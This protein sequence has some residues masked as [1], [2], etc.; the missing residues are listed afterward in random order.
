MSVSLA[1]N[2]AQR[3][4]QVESEA[5]EKQ[6]EQATKR[7][8]MAALA[9]NVQDSQT[10]LEDRLNNLR[11][12]ADQM[13]LAAAEARKKMLSRKLT[14]QHLRADLSKVKAERWRKRCAAGVEELI[15]RQ[16]VLVDEGVEAALNEPAVVP[17]V[18]GQG[19]L[20]STHAVEEEM[21]AVGM[22]GLGEFQECTRLEGKDR[23]EEEEA[24]CALK[25]QATLFAGDGEVA[26]AH[27]SPAKTATSPANDAA[28]SPANRA[29]APSR[30]DLATLQA[31]MAIPPPARHQLPR[32]PP[33]QA[34][35]RGGDAADPC[36]PLAVGKDVEGDT[37][38]RLDL[39]TP[40]SLT[41]PRGVSVEANNSVG[42]QMEEVD[43]PRVSL[44]GGAQQ[45]A[46]ESGRDG[47]ARGEE[48]WRR[49]AREAAGQQRRAEEEK[50]RAEEEQRRAEAVAEDVRKEN[51]KLRTML[52]CFERPEVDEAGRE[53]LRQILASL[54]YHDNASSPPATSAALP[55]A[56]STC[57]RAEAAPP[58][59]VP[60]VAAETAAA[61]AAATVAAAA[62]CPTSHPAS[63][64]EAEEE[65]GTA[66]L[67]GGPQ[68]TDHGGASRSARSASPSPAARFH[69]AHGP[70]DTA[71]EEDA[72]AVAPVAEA[73]TPAAPSAAVVAAG[74]DS[75]AEAA[76]AAATSPPPAAAA[77][78]AAAAVAI[79]SQ[80][81][82]HTCA[83]AQFAT[84]EC[85]QDSDNNSQSLAP[86]GVI[87]LSDDTVADESP[88]ES[89][90]AAAASG[91]IGDGERGGG[92]NS[93]EKSG[94]SFAGK[95]VTGSGDEREAEEMGAGGER[96]SEERSAEGKDRAES[97]PEG[98]SSVDLT[99][100]IQRLRARSLR[101]LTEAEAKRRAEEEGAAASA[102][103]GEGEREGRGD[104]GD[105]E[106]GAAAR[107]SQG[108]CEAAEGKGLQEIAGAAACGGGDDAAHAGSDATG[109]AAGDIAQ[110][111]GNGRRRGRSKA[112]SGVS[113][114]E[115]LVE[116]GGVGAVRKGRKRAAE[117]QETS[118]GS[119][120]VTRSQVRKSAG[121]G[122]EEGS[123]S[124][125]TRAESMHEV[126]MTDVSVADQ[127]F[128]AAAAADDDDDVAPASAPAAAVTTAAATA[129]DSGG[130][131][132]KRS[133]GKA[134]STSAA[135]FLQGRSRSVSS[136]RGKRGCSSNASGSSR[137]GNTGSSKRQSRKLSAANCNSDA[138]AGG[139]AESDA[140]AAHGEKIFLTPPLV[141]TKAGNEKQDS[142]GEGSGKAA[143]TGT[144]GRGLAPGA[145]ELCSGR[146]GV[147]E[148]PM[149]GEPPH[150][151]GEIAESTAGSQP[152]RS[153]SLSAARCLAA[154]GTHSPVLT[155][156]FQRAFPVPKL[157]GSGSA[158]SCS[159]ASSSRSSRSIRRG[160]SSRSSM[161]GGSGGSKKGGAKGGAGGAGSRSA[162]EGG[163][164]GGG[165]AGVGGVSSQ[166]S[167]V[168]QALAFH[169]SEGT[170]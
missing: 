154:L 55:P 111:T 123:K 73:P 43:Q 21:E 29:T 33:P 157:K 68:G 53:I 164:R 169:E 146:L 76:P 90:T 25:E 145:S 100:M 18:G 16:A 131:S 103:E 110:D 112:D 52:R 6:W 134:S 15:K 116:E 149:V 162:G 23:G 82:S 119:G 109:A 14:I 121:K 38:A 97:C 79:P 158:S 114:R 40:E 44:L 152:I 46:E 49:V 156:F 122:E 106:D 42:I 67:S 130:E 167:L 66:A 132:C 12:L 150:T 165:G 70:P 143:G 30:D 1:G 99:D 32:T 36:P 137:S 166:L 64:A 126:D 86:P 31:A 37:A 87:S 161:G 88:R 138:A 65:R 95:G 71:A 147:S 34:A 113:G 51:E 118:Y 124:Q 135:A 9:R 54:P 10:A 94:G 19:N 115:V 170:R 91:A 108:E 153:T 155:S 92:G 2:A 83:P 168:R 74:E 105:A 45:Q 69:S 96:G 62:A 127:P 141:P 125:D 27:G 144:K 139:E 4:V 77:A 28:P 11:L 60:T 13:R 48:E 61:G 7:S 72:A 56:P 17:V 89:A 63:A 41:T 128:M 107:G 50:R 140:A 58:S 148:T 80:S 47:G 84:L 120:R 142:G 39:E 129:A 104:A 22:A 98:G 160:G 101:A 24:Q 59:P 85:S 81:S 26:V 5:R 93:K 163:A 136:G 3:A 57:A 78:A 102:R 133:K 8:S 159:G 151:A 75:A 20:P 35:V 117:S